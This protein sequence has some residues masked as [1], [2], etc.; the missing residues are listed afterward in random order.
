MAD[1][2]VVVVDDSPISVDITEQTVEV[3]ISGAPGPPGE[4]GEPGV[5]GDKNYLF[6]QASPSSTWVIT[7]NL[8]KYVA[9][10]VIV[11]G[12][13]VDAEVTY[14]SVNSVTVSFSSPES[15]LAVCN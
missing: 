7:H 15:G 11:G 3:T 14:N 5:D 9:V 8:N 12:I 1:E 2:I 6:T 4:Q 10:T 13:E